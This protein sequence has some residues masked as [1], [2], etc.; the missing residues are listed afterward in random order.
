MKRSARKARELDPTDGQMFVLA[1][2]EKNHRVYTIQDREWAE[3]AH[4]GNSKH[5]IQEGTEGKKSAAHKWVKPGV[6]GVSRIL[7]FLRLLV[8]NLV[9]VRFVQLIILLCL[10]NKGVAPLRCKKKLRKKKGVGL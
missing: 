6:S 1:S 10:G 8:L 5:C 3:P 2:V 9:S 4:W 7:P